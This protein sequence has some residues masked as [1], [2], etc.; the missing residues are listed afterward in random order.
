MDSDIRAILN[1]IKWDESCHMS[2]LRVSYIDRGRPGNRNV[3]SGED[4]V[5]IKQHFFETADALIPFHRIMVIRYG[6]AVLFR[7]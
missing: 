4:I 6:D 5:D 3:A 7:R 1:K 2:Q